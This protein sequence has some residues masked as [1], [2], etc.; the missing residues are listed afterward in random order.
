MYRN[1]SLNTGLDPH[2]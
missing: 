1:Y 2:I